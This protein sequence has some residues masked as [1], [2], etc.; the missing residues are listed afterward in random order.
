MCEVA[1]KNALVTGASGGI[2]EAIVREFASKGINVWAHASREREEFSEKMRAIAEEYHVWIKPVYFNLEQEEEIK[3]AVKAIIQEK[4][5][6]D[7]LVINAG[8]SPRQLLSMSKMDDLRRTMEIN[9]FSQV[10]IIQMISRVMSRQK[11]G[12]IVTIGSVSGCEYPERGGLAYGGSKAALIFATRVIARELADHNIRVNSVSPGFI[13]TKMW[14][15]R[16]EAMM[17]E[18]MRRSVMKRMGKPE[19]VAKVVCFMAS[20]DSSYMTGTNVVV[21]GGGRVTLLD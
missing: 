14:A 3:E 7:I 10:L 13:D 5:P 15:D 19:E 11:S 16:S 6:I 21:H 1:V 17:E 12:S 20:D 18:G 9:Y 2:G 4:R 8:I